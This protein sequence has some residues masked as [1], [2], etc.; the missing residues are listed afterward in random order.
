MSNAM[1][2]NSHQCIHCC[3]TSCKHLKQQAGE[4]GLE[5]VHI[6]PTP[7]SYSGDPADESMCRDYCCK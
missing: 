3:V 1:N 6:E 2:N 5:S 4:C 7:M